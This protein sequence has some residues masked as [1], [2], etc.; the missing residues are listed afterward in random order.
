[1]TLASAVAIAAIHL[2]AE[3]GLFPDNTPLGPNF[4]LSS[5]VFRDL[6]TPASFVNETAGEKGLQFSNSGMEVALPSAVK[7]VDLRVGTFAGPITI[8]AKDRTG[9]VVA[10][11]SIPGL[12]RYVDLRLLAPEIALVEFTGGGNEAILV[13]ICIDVAVC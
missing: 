7:V 5:F 3:F 13:R 12:N 2:C 4:T 9:S 1:M 8:S 10:T 6:G 11:Q